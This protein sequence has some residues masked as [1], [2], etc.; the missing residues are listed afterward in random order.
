[1]GQEAL[2]HK[3]QVSVGEGRLGFILAFTRAFSPAA[4]P[5]CARIARH[6]GKAGGAMVLVNGQSY[7]RLP[8]PYSL[9]FVF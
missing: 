6:S 4:P 1:M 7:T 5:D 8:S 2:P 3:K 9:R